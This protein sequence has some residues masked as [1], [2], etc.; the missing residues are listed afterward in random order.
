MM[1]Y[2]KH[3]YLF[4]K[5][6]KSTWD[7]LFGNVKTNPEEQLWIAATSRPI[8]LPVHTK[9]KVFN[10]NTKFKFR[11]ENVSM[12]N[13]SRYITLNRVQ[14]TQLTVHAS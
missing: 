6:V 12:A 8:D 7:C 9:S 10:I 4:L 1:P 3:N 2:S 13:F 14:R 5:F 11:T